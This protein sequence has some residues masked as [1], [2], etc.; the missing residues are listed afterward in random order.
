MPKHYKP[1]F[2]QEVAELVVDRGYSIREASEAMCS[3]TLN[4]ATY[5]EVIL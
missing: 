3:G 5:L 1:A 4:L 2:R